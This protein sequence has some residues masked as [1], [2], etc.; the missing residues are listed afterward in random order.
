MKFTNA[1][2]EELKQ[3]ILSLEID[4]TATK[5]HYVKNKIGH[6][7]QERFIWDVFFSTGFSKAHRRAGYLDTHI[8]TATNKAIEELILL[9]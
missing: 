7:P 2:Y 3:R 8:R 9:E 6:N 1:H 4:L 5:T